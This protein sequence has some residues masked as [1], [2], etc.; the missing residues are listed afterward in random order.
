[1]C[2]VIGNTW[3]LVSL[4]WKGRFSSAYLFLAHLTI[5]GKNS[6]LGNS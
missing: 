6:G 2:A 3:F 1:M 5:A 4:S